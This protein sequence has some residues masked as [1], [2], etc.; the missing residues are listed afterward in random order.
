MM[1]LSRMAL[2]DFGKSAVPR[3]RVQAPDRAAVPPRMRGMRHAL[4]LP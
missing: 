2:A 3:L 1:T 4:G